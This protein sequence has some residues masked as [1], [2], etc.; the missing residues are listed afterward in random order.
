MTI[1]AS[2]GSAIAAVMV[3]Y[4]VWIRLRPSQRIDEPFP[5]T[6]LS[7]VL[8]RSDSEEKTGNLVTKESE[9]PQELWTS[10]EVLNVERRA[11]F[12]KVRWFLSPSI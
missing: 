7:E 5:R 10:T 4:L 3:V 1:Q 8:A 9:Y 11:I 2:V 12:S 6:S